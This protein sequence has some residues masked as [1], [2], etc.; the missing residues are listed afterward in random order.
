MRPQMRSRWPVIVA[1]LLVGLV[2]AG[3]FAARPLSD[4]WSA[5]QTRQTA[6][7]F[8]RDN[9]AVKHLARLTV[10]TGLLDCSPPKGRTT[11]RSPG[12]ICWTGDLEPRDAS[13]AVRQA[14]TAVGARQVT[15]H[16]RTLK[17]AVVICRIDAQLGGQPVA[18][19]IGPRVATSSPAESQ[20][21][22][23]P[24]AEDPQGGGATN[25]PDV[26][27][28]W[29]GSEVALTIFTDLIPNTPLKQQQ[30]TPG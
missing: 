12:W 8:G 16:C 24:S 1:L 17:L 13:A 2:V 23:A 15:E 3:G 4:R 6:A 18:A 26:P 19:F 27:R 30:V 22:P 29:D 11:S 7:E 5:R 28:T 20:S 14:L 9:P 10:P 21:P 25:P